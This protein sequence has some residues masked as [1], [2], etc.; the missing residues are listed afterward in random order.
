[1]GKYVVTTYGKWEEQRKKLVTKLIS[2]PE[3]IAKTSKEKIDKALFDDV[4]SAMVEIAYEYTR[5][6]NAEVVAKQLTL[7]DLT[8]RAYELSLDVVLDSLSKSLA[9]EK[10]LLA[11]FVSE[12][13]QECKQAINS[14][15]DIS[16]IIG[17]LSIKAKAEAAIEL[18]GNNFACLYEDL[19]KKLPLQD[20]DLIECARATINRTIK[21]ADYGDKAEN[22]RQQLIYMNEIAPV[23]TPSEE[24]KALFKGK[25]GK[26]MQEYKAEVA[27]NKASLSTWQSSAAVMTATPKTELPTQKLGSP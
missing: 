20:P 4:N 21:P 18:Y 26:T 7:R 17:T 13:C 22:V 23:I 27:K 8:I 1:M 15:I 5:E 24:F 11:P 12:F 25:T 16:M 19:N 6:K 14:I 2:H 9:I 3:I 10:E